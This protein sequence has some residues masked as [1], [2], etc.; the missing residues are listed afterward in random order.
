M[1]A[2]PDTLTMSMYADGA[3]PPE[4][5]AAVEKHVGAC[6][7]CRELVT[8]LRREVDLLN[9]TLRRTA[10]AEPDLP[11]LPRFSAPASF[12]DFALANLTIGL[13]FWLGQFLW[14]TLLGELAVDIASRF[15]SIYVPDTYQLVNAFVMQLLEK[16][17]AMFYSYLNVVVLGLLVIGSLLAILKYRKNGLP[18]AACIGLL[19]LPLLAPTPADALEFWREPTGTIT[20]AAHEAYDDTMIL[21]AEMVRI[22]GNVTGDV[23]ATGRSI[24]VSGSISG[25]L[26]AFGDT[27][28]I[29]G[30]VGGATISAA[31]SLMLEHADGAGD[32]WGAAK[33]ISINRDSIV[34]GNATLAGDSVMVEGKVARDLTGFADTI[35]VRGELG[36]T[37]RAWAGAIRL[38]NDAHVHGNVTYHAAS[39]DSLKQADSARIDGEVVYEGQAEDFGH[40]NRYA[41]ARFYLW[42]L[43]RLGAAFLVGLALFWLVPGLQSLSI[44]AG[45]DSLRTAGLGLLVLIAVPIIALLTAFTLVGLPLALI[46]VA[47]WILALYLAKIVLGA[48]V[49]RMLLADREGIMLPLLI[50]L[51]IV[52]VA[53]NLPWIG[54][55]VGFVL[56]LVGLGLLAQYLWKAV[57]TSRAA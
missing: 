31:S 30:K 28:R 11:A 3:L 52:L 55:I 29:S 46:A 18:P 23:I 7:T 54:G 4:A 6:S 36:R 38:G 1:T 14:K 26:I 48:T 8:L 24:E 37:L 43:A 41:T 16:G 57:N 47:A 51:A 12:R 19:A 40:E 5:V 53:G 42:Q 39:R 35:D 15:A 45:M 2:H 49:G 13:V 33:F 27:V 32:L 56:T 22:E 21:A 20:I 34:G 9:E 10:V 44:A 17:T 50:G 25:N